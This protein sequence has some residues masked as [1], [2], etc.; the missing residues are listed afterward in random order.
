MVPV[1]IAKA[2]FI[3]QSGKKPGNLSSESPETRSRNQPDSILPE[4][5]ESFNRRDL[6]GGRISLL[7]KKGILNL[8]RRAEDASVL[9]AVNSHLVKCSTS[10]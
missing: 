4:I 7:V 6:F 8:S 10:L 5:S 9:S 2:R 3:K 1:P